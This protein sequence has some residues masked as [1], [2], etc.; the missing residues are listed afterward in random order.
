MPLLFVI[1]EFFVFIMSL[2]LV[3]FWT[4][5]G[6]YILPSFIGVLGISFWGQK[7]FRGL[8]MQLAQS[9]DPIKEVL[10]SFSG[11]I[12]FLLLIPP[13]FTTRVLGIF[14]IFPLTRWFVV[15]LSQFFVFKKMGPTGFMFYQF[16]KDHFRSAE[17]EPEF[18]EGDRPLRD[19]TPL[20]PKSIESKKE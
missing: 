1:L 17:N 13:T 7:G 9:Q 6:L 19:V 16:G 10:K 8:Q 12:G 20:E 3:G 14:L 4:T 11:L 18:Y 5:L 15:F 2:K